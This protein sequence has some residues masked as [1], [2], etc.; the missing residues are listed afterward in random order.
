MIRRKALVLSHGQMAESTLVTG[1]KENNTV[2]ELIPLP[3]EKR[4]MENGRTAR[5]SDGSIKLNLMLKEL[6]NNQTCFCLL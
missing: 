4:N 6:I 5:E 2:K 3:R 1:D